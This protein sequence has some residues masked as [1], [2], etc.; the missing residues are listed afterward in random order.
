MNTITN[1]KITKKCAAVAKKLLA[2]SA[3]LQ[4]SQ[5]QQASPRSRIIAERPWTLQFGF[6]L[7][8]GVA[9]DSEG[10]AADGIEI[11]M[12]DNRHEVA[13]TVDAYWNPHKGDQS[14]N[15]IKVSLD[16][17]LIAQ[18]Y[19]PVRFDDGNDQVLTIS[20]AVVPGLLAIAHSPQVNAPPVVHA[21]VNCPFAIDN[22]ISFY[23]GTIGNGTGNVWLLDEISL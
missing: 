6:N 13:V 16:G 23:A 19:V 12:T 3:D 14:G 10:M 8:G 21:V 4:P 9:S 2:E 17:E 22:D 5:Q 18:A 20:N 1:I 7:S 15:S 11:C